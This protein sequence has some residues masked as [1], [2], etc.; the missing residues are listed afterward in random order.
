MADYKN[1]VPFI[2]RVEGGLSSDPKDSASKNSS[3]CGSRN[4]LPIHTNKGITWTSFQ[5]LA[6]KAGYVASCDNFI[7]MP[8]DIWLKVYK[9][10]YWDAVKGDEIRNQAIAN[11][12]VE[13]TWG[14]GLGCT[15]FTVCKSGTRPFM[16]R[17]FKENYNK[18]FSTIDEFVAFVNE[19]DKKGKTPE[20]FE[21]LHQFR[22]ERYKGMPSAP[23]HLTGWL[24]RL[25]EFYILNK[26]YAIS[27]QEKIKATGLFVGLGLI[28]FGGFYLYRKLKK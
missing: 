18:N 14:S 10:G 12:F 13:M 15:N 5:N 11:V 3:P 2:R 16:N 17:F 22:A 7:K 25:D 23:Y 27:N 26:P 4:G 19:L 9:V 20:L 24:R 21:Q 8:D 6:S 1:I 28:V